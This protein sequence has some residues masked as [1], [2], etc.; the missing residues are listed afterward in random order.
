VAV[1]DDE[2]VDAGAVHA[3]ADL[4]EGG[5]GG[6]GESVSVPRKR[7]ML[8]RGADLL[9]RQKRDGQILRQHRAHA[10]KIRLGNVGIGADRQM[11]PVLLR[12]PR[13]EAPR[14]ARGRILRRQGKPVGHVCSASCPR[15]RATQ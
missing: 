14:C 1:D 6:L 5:E 7:A 9:H 8:V 13:R 12:P 4:D 15:R 11:R 10:R 3:F 2:L